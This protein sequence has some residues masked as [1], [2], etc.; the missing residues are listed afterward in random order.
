MM[1]V[2]PNGYILEAHGLFKA[3][4]ANNDAGILKS[5]LKQPDGISQ[6]IQPG[7]HFILDRGFR[8]IQAELE[9]AGYTMHMPSCI[10]GR[11]S[12]T[13]QEANASRKV[14]LTRWSVEAVNGR[15]KHVFKFM[16]QTIHNSYVFG[17]KLNKMFRICCALINAFY[18]P[19]YTDQ[20]KH[21]RVLKEVENR[22][23]KRNELKDLVVEKG[24]ERQ[25]KSKWE[26]L[27]ESSVPEFPKYTEEELF[28]LT[29]GVWQ[30]KNAIWYAKQH[31]KDDPSFKIMLCKQDRNI[32]R[33]RIDSRFS[34]S[35][36]HSCWIKMNPEKDGPERVESYFC[37]CKNGERTLGACS[38]I[39][40]VIWYLGFHRH[41]RK[42][43]KL[44]SLSECLLDAK[45]SLES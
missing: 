26:V 39:V 33:A 4:G 17:G 8:D 31:M 12:F 15:V 43:V 22:M 24:W 19:L 32:L 9:N 11:K 2:F 42:E 30:I 3:N 1:I 7:D 14:T 6:W 40:C 10:Y 20:R 27:N 35:A 5:M 36:H 23:A 18:A 28:D 34:S 41:Q 38:H 25:T 45:L 44:R 37:N 13:W 16:D 29:V 21:E